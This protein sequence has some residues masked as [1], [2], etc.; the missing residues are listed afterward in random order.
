MKEDA[1]LRRTCHFIAWIGALSTT[2]WCGVSTLAAEKPA[3]RTREAATAVRGQSPVAGRKRV[4]PKELLAEA[5]HEFNGGRL[6]EAETLARE[7]QQSGVRAPLFGDSPDKLLEDIAECR[8]VE[9]AWK[10]DS[11]SVAARKQRVAYFLKRARQVAEEG[12]GANAE[13]YVR[14]ADAAGLQGEGPLQSKLALAKKLMA[15]RVAVARGSSAGEDDASLPAVDEAA[16]LE[17]LESNDEGA[18]PQALK[19]PARSTAPRSEGAIAPR[20]QPAVDDVP[21]AFPAD[22]NEAVEG[23]ADE[24]VADET[25]MPAEEAPVD[26]APVDDTPID[27]APVEESAAAGND[28]TPSASDEL[29]DESAA[30]GDEEPLGLGDDAPADTDSGEPAPVMDEVPGA[31]ETVEGS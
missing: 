30:A 18:A 19:K 12:D 4:N 23:A 8:Q 9:Q 31:D 16:L 25:A 26:A 5:R 13:R 10:K 20:T 2:T 27:E 24:T 11:Q 29:L 21:P 14:L 6:T 22:A 15:S 7:C 28:R 3:A 17:A 1:T